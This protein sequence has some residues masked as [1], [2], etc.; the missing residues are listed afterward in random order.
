MS[1]QTDQIVRIAREWI[2]TPF[3]HQ[4]SVKG[5]GC[6]CIGLVRGIFAELYGYMP[7]VPAYS[8]DWGDSNGNE[9]IIAAGFEYMEPVTSSPAMPGDVIAIRWKKGL[10]AKHV[11][12]LSDFNRAI[13]AYQGTPVTEVYLN[14]WWFTK[15]A[16]VFRFPE[17]K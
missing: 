16:L 2:G 9:D 5:V 15:V 11:M 1:E 12:L 10:V 14:D 6:D 3:H 13:H 4:A 17:V 8:W 7:P